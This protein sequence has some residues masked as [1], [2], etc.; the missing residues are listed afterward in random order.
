[1]KNNMNNLLKTV[2]CGLRFL[3]LHE[4][5]IQFL[6]PILVFCNRLIINRNKKAKSILKI[7]LRKLAPK[8][9]CSLSGLHKKC[10]AVFTVKPTIISLPKGRRIV[11][12]IKLKNQFLK[13]FFC[14]GRKII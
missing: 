12:K 4:V 14:E 7:Y 6:R 8:I 3:L 13:N 11:K 2:C 5:F 10:F 9:S 1:M